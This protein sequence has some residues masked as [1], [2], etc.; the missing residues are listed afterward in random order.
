MS[1]FVSSPGFLTL[2]LVLCVVRFLIFDDFDNNFCVQYL[3]F[4][5]LQFSALYDKFHFACWIAFVIIFSYVRVNFIWVISENLASVDTNIKS[6]YVF[7]Q[8]G[9]EKLWVWF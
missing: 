3:G 7:S 9:G 2:N 4:S 5:N 1:E 8:D 6:F